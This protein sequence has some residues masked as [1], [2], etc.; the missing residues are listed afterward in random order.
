MSEANYIIYILDLNNI[1]Q[2]R[3]EVIWTLTKCSKKLVNQLLAH[4]YKHC[5]YKAYTSSSYM[6]HHH[7][8]D[9]SS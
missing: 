1:D 6:I 9:T 8:V 7:D 5:T 3:R 2:T 4:N